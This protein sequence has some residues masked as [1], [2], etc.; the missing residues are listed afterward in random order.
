MAF[1]ANTEGS[2]ISE[3]FKLLKEAGEL[4]PGHICDV[5]LYEDHLIIT[6]CISKNTAQLDYKQ[7]INVLYEDIKYTVPKKAPGLG[8]LI[9]GSF[10]GGMGAIIGGLAGASKETKTVYM[11]CLTIIYNTATRDTKR[12][13]FEDTSCFTGKKLVAKLKELCGIEDN[14]KRENEIKHSHL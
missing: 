12:I 2:I 7:I 1:F 4:T 13:Y 6:D 11:K 8:G 5:A 3:R 10:F 9:V 14:T